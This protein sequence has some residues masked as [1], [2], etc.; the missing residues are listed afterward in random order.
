M[1]SLGEDDVVVGRLEAAR[2]DLARA[3]L[4]ALADGM[5]VDDV[6][7]HLDITSDE[8]ERVIGDA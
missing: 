6:A 4:T 3:I 1:G 8:V 2:D 5:S 7:S